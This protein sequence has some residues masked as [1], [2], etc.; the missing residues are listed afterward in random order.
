MLG[1][2]EFYLL[3][4]QWRFIVLQKYFFKYLMIDIL[5]PYIYII[6]VLITFFLVIGS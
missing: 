5:S 3:F 2:I 1:L 4:L 6:L